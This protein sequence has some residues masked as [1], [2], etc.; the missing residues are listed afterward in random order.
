MISSNKRKDIDT[1]QVFLMPTCTPEETNLVDDYVFVGSARQF[2][3]Q[4]GFVVEDGETWDGLIGRFNQVP[5][6]RPVLAFDSFLEAVKYALESDFFA[7][8]DDDDCAT[9]RQGVSRH[10]LAA[11]IDDSADAGEVAEI[12]RLLGASV[13]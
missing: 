2:A 5:V 7:S 11:A 10:I 12:R 4:T 1:R 3:E 13:S 9:V 8:D 6:L